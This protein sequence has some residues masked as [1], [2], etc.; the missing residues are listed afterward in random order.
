[1]WEN[2]APWDGRLVVGCERDLLAAVGDGR[3][4]AELYDALD[5]ARLELD[6]S[7]GGIR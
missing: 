1:V 4:S 7:I 6:I 5:K 3:F 2:E